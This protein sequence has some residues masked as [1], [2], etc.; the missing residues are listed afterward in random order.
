[1]KMNEFSYLFSP[2]FLPS[3][4]ICIYESYACACVCVLAAVIDWTAKH[5]W[6][7]FD[8]ESKKRVNETDRIDLLDLTNRRLRWWCAF[9]G[10]R[11]REAK[12]KRAKNRESNVVKA[13]V[14]HRCTTASGISHINLTSGFHCTACNLTLYNYCL[15][16]SL[17][18]STQI[19]TTVH[20]LL[21]QRK[22]ETYG[23]TDKQTN[24]HETC[25]CSVTRSFTAHIIVQLSFSRST[26]RRHLLSR[27]RMSL[28]RMGLQWMNEHIQSRAKKY[29]LSS[30]HSYNKLFQIFP[31]YS[32]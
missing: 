20:A 2:Y 24:T 5:A 29:T 26:T 17:L 6:S 16:N 10:A 27:G 14:L 31:P 28:K 32:V 3:W 1:M 23:Q 21:G 4:K 7:T 30:S 13:H 25:T 15:L 22:G 18:L 8:L 19:R 12:E 11:K 9:E